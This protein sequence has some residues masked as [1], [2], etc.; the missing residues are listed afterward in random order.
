MIRTLFAGASSACFELENSL[1]F[2][3]ER[4]FPVILN[5]AVLY[6]TD[7]NVF[8]VYGL[9]PN[10]SYKL[11]AGPE[12]EEFIF[13]TAAEACCFSVRDFGAKGDGAADD[14]AALQKA[15]DFLPPDGRLAVPAGTYLTGPLMLKSHMT[16]EL[17]EGAVLLGKTE[18]EAYPV[19]PGFARDLDRNEDVPVGVWEGNAY[20]MRQ[21]LLCAAYA[22][23]LTV[24]GPGTADGNAQNGGW[25]VRPIPT[26]IARPRLVF[27][28]HC[29]NVTLH[30]FLAQNSASWNFHPYH[31]ENV[32]FLDLRISA[33]ADSPNTDGIDPEA[34]DRVEIIGCRFSVG[35]DCIAIKSG[36]LELERLIRRPASRHTVR[37][38]RM[39]FGHGAVTLGSEIAGGVRDLRVERCEFCRTDRGLRVKTRRGRGKDSVIDGVTFEN[40]RMDGVKT[41]LVINMWYNCND[42]DRYSDYVKCRE[43]LPVDERTPYLGSFTFRHMDCVNCHAAAGFF[44]GLPEQPIGS[45]TVEDIRFSF[46]EDAQPDYPAMQNDKELHCR[47]GLCFTN[48]KEVLVRGVS[49]ENVS[50]EETVRRNVGRFTRE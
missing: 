19:V 3:A 32:R 10:T 4:S 41:P 28:T 20:T 42:P 43:P 5:G 45:V 34:C 44:D 8:S 26:D 12:G 18:K 35:D 24:T 22:E 38:C 13:R 15:I 11:T 46:A 33:P 29:R 1:P 21:A 49:F 9:Q 31:S 50:G 39:C 23:D 30:G 14:T 40:V 27:L 17:C 25:W 2:R 7:R 48:V 47:A 37:N 6:E 16:L 36:K